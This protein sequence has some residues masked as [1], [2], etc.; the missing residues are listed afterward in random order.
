MLQ[1]ATPNLKLG[2]EARQHMC[3]K[4]SQGAKL[5]DGDAFLANKGR[6][7]ARAY[8][9]MD[10]LH[11]QRADVAQEL[12]EA[13]QEIDAKR[14]QEAGRL[15]LNACRFGKRD[16]VGLARMLNSE[17]Y[18]RA[19]TEKGFEELLKTLI[20]AR[21]EEQEDLGSIRRP[22]VDVV[23]PVALDLREARREGEHQGERREAVLRRPEKGLAVHGVRVAAPEDVDGLVVREALLARDLL[24]RM[25]ELM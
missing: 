22:F 14:Q 2:K 11:Q 24:C 12:H 9:K 23:H 3:K 17:D 6:A 25:G 5:L 7:V 1:K 20:P 15:K 4:S 19:E 13:R 16:F 21:L 8:G 18:S 10:V